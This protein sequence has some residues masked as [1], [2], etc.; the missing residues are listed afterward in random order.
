[1][2]MKKLKPVIALILVF[3]SVVSVQPSANAGSQ[4]RKVLSGW[5]PYYSMKTALPAAIANADLIREVMPFWYQLKF[6]GAKNE[7]VVT[8]LY[9]PA[10]P[11]VP[12]SVPLTA[13]RN[14]GLTII[15]TITDGTSEL[16]LAKLLANPTSRTQVVNAITNLVTTNNYDG[17]DLDFE[18]F[19]FVD[20]NTTWNSTKLN[21]IAF[22]KE[23]SSALKAKN[24]LLSVTTPYVYN[25][26]EAQKGYF[27][28][29]WADIAAY[30]D[31]LRIMTYDYSISRAGPLG[32]LAW[33]EKTIKYAISVMP[34][35]KVYVGIPG[36]GRD[37]VTKVE[38]ICPVEVAKVVKVG[39]KAATFLLRDAAALSQSYGVFP[40]YD[41]AFGEVNFTY[42]KVYSGLTAAG[43]ATTCTATRTA[44]YQDARSF[45]SRIGFVSKY[46]LG[47]VALWTF[48]MEDMAG[49]QAIRDAA[50]AIAP[51]QVISTASLT[52]ANSELTSPLEFGSILELN[53][54]FQLPDKLPINNLLVRIETKS[55]N[56]TQWREIATSTTGVDGSIRV[57]LLLSKSTMLRAHTD[58]TWERLESFSQE[59][60]VVINRRISVDAPVSVLRSQ[61]FAITGVLSP[62]L[63]GVP[64]QL[65]QQQAGKWI[66]VGA[67]VV[68][69]TNGAFTIST[70]SV[71]KGFA[72]FRVSVAK[73]TLWNQAESDVITVVI[74]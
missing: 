20:K 42:N 25:P 67:P 74:R 24:K 39:A 50:L 59:L 72:K 43:L 7:A 63:S 31:R 69:D 35:S 2:N 40:K 18:G 57:P 15:P 41:E 61:A 32:P 58:D 26:A 56:E 9:A 4:P 14:A 22:I 1:M 51:D 62:H 27:V 52:T 12:I 73:D 64:V 21:W 33:T 28:Y 6:N 45:T 29:A 19:A 8:N 68:T 47:G 17:I 49:S 10:N 66:S 23:L 65:L 34:A 16:V 44:W 60:P 37:W 5:I 11:S 13:M 36:Y 53:A 48:G 70:T 46:R 54:T 55:E 71:Q 3:S 38:G 30:I